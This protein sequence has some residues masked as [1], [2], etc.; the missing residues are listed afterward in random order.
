MYGLFVFLLKAEA[1]ALELELNFLKRLSAKVT[2]FHHILCCLVCKVFNRVDTRSLQAVERTNREVEF[3]DSHFEN[4]LLAL[5][6]PQ[7]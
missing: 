1:E 6:V 5:L 7:P 2:N 3:L 4:L